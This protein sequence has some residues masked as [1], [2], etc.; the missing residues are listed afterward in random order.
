MIGVLIDAL[1]A[2][3]NIVSAVLYSIM[4]FFVRGTH[5][6][7]ILYAPEISDMIVNSR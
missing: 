6:P 5:F 7:E 4:E 1:C 3:L 2:F